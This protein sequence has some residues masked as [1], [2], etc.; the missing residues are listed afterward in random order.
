MLASCAGGQVIC[1]FMFIPNNNYI[2]MNQLSQINI[3]HNHMEGEIA[4]M[5]LANEE[6]IFS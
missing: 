3:S 2:V 1:L 6:G 4:K 5:L